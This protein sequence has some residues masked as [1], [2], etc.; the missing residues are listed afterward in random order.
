MQSSR[1]FFQ[2][3]QCLVHAICCCYWEATCSPP[4]FV[5]NFPSD[6][7]APP[8]LLCAQAGKEL[9]RGKHLLASFWL[10]YVKH[11]SSMRKF[12]ARFLRSFVSANLVRRLRSQKWDFESRKNN[13]KA[14][15]ME[16]RQQSNINWISFSSPTRQTTV[17]SDRVSPSSLET[18]PFDD[19]AELLWVLQCRFEQSQSSGET[20]WHFSFRIVFRSVM[21]YHKLSHLI[22]ATGVWRKLVIESEIFRYAR[23]IYATLRQSRQP[24]SPISICQRQRFIRLLLLLANKKNSTM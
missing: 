24:T 22:G 1:A 11:N 12:C 13:K 5:F 21:W 9:V 10:H 2:P 6:R 4:V 15:I 18:K 23:Q 14:F 19:I 3:T 20:L 16:M 17:D 8:P 7:A